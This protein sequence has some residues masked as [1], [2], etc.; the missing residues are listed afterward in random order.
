MSKFTIVLLIITLVCL[1]ALTFTRS[2][3]TE[4]R[5]TIKGF[6]DEE[7]GEP[8]R[9]VDFL[10][11]TLPDLSERVLMIPAYTCCINHLYDG[12]IQAGDICT[13]EIDLFGVVRKATCKGQ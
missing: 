2:V 11:V 4:L 1:I 9:Y 13:F 8:M 5:A 3:R 7:F 10:T 6:Q 12:D